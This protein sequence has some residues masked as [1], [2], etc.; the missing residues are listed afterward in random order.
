MTKDEALL[1]AIEHDLSHYHRQRMAR[2]QGTCIAKIIAEKSKE[3]PDLV[4]VEQL[5]A[6]L[7]QLERN[8]FNV[9]ITEQE[10]L[11][12]LRN[13]IRANKT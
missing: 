8:K 13:R 3:Q 10:V 5:R 2:L 1:Q 11:Q 7:I 9:E 4:L 6:E 12:P